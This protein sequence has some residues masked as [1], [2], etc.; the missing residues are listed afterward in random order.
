MEGKRFITTFAQRY[1]GLIVCSVIV[2]R[3]TGVNYLSTDTGIT[4]LLDKDGKI[5]I[6]GPETRYDYITDKQL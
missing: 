4:P 3:L 5:I 2:D 6:T 1:A